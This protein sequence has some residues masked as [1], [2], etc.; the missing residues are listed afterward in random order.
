MW[1]IIFGTVLTMISIIM[2]VM[3]ISNL[4]ELAWVAYIIIFIPCIS[5]IYDFSKINN[6]EC[7]QC[8]RIGKMLFSGKDDMYKIMHKEY[9]DYT[10]EA[11]RKMLIMVKCDIECE[12]LACVSI[13][14]MNM[15]NSAYSYF[16]SFSGNQRNIGGTF[17]SCIFP[18]VL[19]F[20]ITFLFL[21]YK[22]KFSNTLKMNIIEG[23]LQKNKSIVNGNERTR[24]CNIKI[25]RH[26]N[27]CKTLI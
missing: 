25:L 12:N 4:C 8:R 20:L 24:L 13:S 16:Y 22:I 27:L 3:V 21:F 10:L 19:M 26:N 23:L 11:L 15:I 9:S 17:S 18:T 7:K 14:I 5:F 6:K 2:M 1:K